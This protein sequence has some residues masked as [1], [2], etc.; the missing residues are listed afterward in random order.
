MG[1]QSRKWIHAL[2]ILAFFINF[3]DKSAS[4]ILTV[5]HAGQSLNSSGPILSHT[6]QKQCVRECMRRGD[7]LS[8]NYWRSDLRCQLNPSTVGPGVVLVPDPDC[9]YMVKSTQPPEILSGPCF[10]TSCSMRCTD[11]SSG[12]S[13]CGP[14]ISALPTTTQPPPTSPLT[15]TTAQTTTTIDFM[16]AQIMYFEYF[17]GGSFDDIVVDWKW[18]N[19][20]IIDPN[21]LMNYPVSGGPGACLIWSDIHYLYDYP[22]S[23]TIPAICDI[24]MTTSSVFEI[25][26][27]DLKVL[28]GSNISKNYYY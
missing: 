13:Y 11:L 23:I 9:V 24:P 1:L 20:S 10:S 6:G 15:T 28:D 21:Y 7:C 14:V 17:I 19:G 27:G 25:R 12:S 4:V 2:S 16:S 22:C 18:V 5:D 26:S 3:F 8:V